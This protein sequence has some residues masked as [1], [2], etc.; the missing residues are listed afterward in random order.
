MA[1]DPAPSAPTATSAPVSIPPL[2]RPPSLRPKSNLQVVV[3]GIVDF[4]AICAATTLA[5]LKIVDGTFAIV[6]IAL[7]AGVRVAD[8]LGARG[9][10]PPGGLGGVG[11]AMV[12]LAQHLLHRGGSTVVVLGA[13]ALAS[14]QACRLPP[15]D[16]CSP[17]ATRCSPDGIP[18]RCSNS[19]R[20]YHESN[21]VPCVQLGSVCCLANSPYGNNVHACVPSSACLTETQDGGMQ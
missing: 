17:R 16:N 9:G 3:E 19:L 5:A 4:A 6:I 15:P 21:A 20:W 8:V 14:L 7:L 2:P 11:G 18:D 10:L 12:A 1:E 13:L